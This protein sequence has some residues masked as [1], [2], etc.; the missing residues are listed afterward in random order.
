MRKA[1]WPVKHDVDEGDKERFSSGREYRYNRGYIEAVY[2]A[3]NVKPL[4]H[5]F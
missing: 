1:S 3:C 2:V 5:A 4:S